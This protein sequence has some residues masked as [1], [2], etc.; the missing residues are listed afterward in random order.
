MA[1][2]NPQH[3][4]EMPSSLSSYISTKRRPLSTGELRSP[5]SSTYVEKNASTAT[6]H[7]LNGEARPLFQLKRVILR[8]II[9][10]GSLLVALFVIGFAIQSY[11]A[12]NNIVGSQ[13]RALLSIS[14]IVNYTYAN[15]RTLLT[16]S[17]YYG[18]SLYFRPNCWSLYP[19]LFEL[20]TRKRP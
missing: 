5:T 9:E 12:N 16:I 6:Y 1:L 15:L 8:D 20:A 4:P 18:F 13:E 19:E 11:R 14:R 2:S 17:D 3:A 7:R 10:I